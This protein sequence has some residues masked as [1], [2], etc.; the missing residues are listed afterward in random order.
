MRVSGKIHFVKRCSR[1]GCT[2]FVLVFGCGV[3][4]AFQGATHRDTLHRK[5][6]GVTAGAAEVTVADIFLQQPGAAL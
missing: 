1:I 4:A 2:D 3:I 6:E 5:A